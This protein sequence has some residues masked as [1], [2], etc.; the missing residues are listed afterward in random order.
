MAPRAKPEGKGKAAAIADNADA[1]AASDEG[2]E[3]DSFLARCNDEKN[4]T[5]QK[6]PPV[7]SRIVYPQECKTH[8][9]Y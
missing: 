9:L 1:N 3:L 6:L 2:M 7:L 8:R 4:K 5:L